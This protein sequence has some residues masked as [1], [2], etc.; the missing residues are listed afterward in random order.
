MDTLLFMLF[1]IYIRLVLAMIKFDFDIFGVASFIYLTNGFVRQ[2]RMFVKITFITIL[3]LKKPFDGSG[4]PPF[5]NHMKYRLPI[6]SRFLDFQGGVSGFQPVA[7]T[8]FKLEPLACLK[9]IF[10]LGERKLRS[11]QN[12]GNK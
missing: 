7:I 6:I 9:C 11:D 3:Y 8:H 2:A 12:S 1:I 5:A 4:G 10:L